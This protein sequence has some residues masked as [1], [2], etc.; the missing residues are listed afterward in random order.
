MSESPAPPPK[1]RS[2]FR[3][4]LRR[5]LLTL[6]ILAVLLVVVAFATREYFRATGQRALAVEIARLD[7][8]DPK[9]RFDDLMAARALAAPPDAENSAVIVRRV[10]ELMPAGWGKWME[11]RPTADPSLNRRQE[12]KALIR[13]QALTDA[14]RPARDLGLTLRDYPRGYHLVPVEP[15]FFYFLDEWKEARNVA[16]LCRTDAVLAAQDGDSV[17]GLR[18]AHA[19]LNVA[20]SLGNESSL[21]SALSRFACSMISTEAAMRVLALSDTRGATNE[22]VALQA[23]LLAEADEPVLVYALR[24][25]RAVADRFLARLEDGTIGADDLA[26]AAAAKDIP[27]PLAVDSV[28][29]Y[30][31]RGFI[32]E[33][34]RRLLRSMSDYIAAAK[35]PPHERMT[36]TERI[37]DDIW[38]ARDTRYPY[39][40]ELVRHVRIE[41]AASVSVRARLL[42]AATLIACE[43]FRIARGRWP[44][45]L[46]ELPKELLATVP[47]DPYNGEP[48]KF[49]RLPDGITVYSVGEKDTRPNE[50]TNPL[51]G[52]EL[53]W[54]LYDPQQ[55]G[56][57]PLPPKKDDPLADP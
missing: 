52:T 41:M 31:R 3:R 1:R 24:G 46:A 38:D 20:R 30:F 47:V 42:S 8:E 49:A 18:A 10:H 16:D 19:A 7:A 22:L 50:L 5:A 57:P 12:L 15:L 11:S 43:R 4:W 14:T 34:R 28:T 40:L 55:R 33:D 35:G 26:R 21:F 23:A 25:E 56:L 54:R 9:W 13:D 17:R 6:P 48:M 27:K 44:E 53:G 39:H 51:G 2:W 45:S 37:R 32:P 29:L 36:A